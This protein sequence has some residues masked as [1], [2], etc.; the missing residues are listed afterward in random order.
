MYAQVHYHPYYFEVFLWGEI[1]DEAGKCTL[2]ENEE[3]VVFEMPKVTLGQ[4]WPSLDVKDL[5][6]NE[7]HEKRVRAVA[8]SQTR[9]AAKIETALGKNKK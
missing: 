5:P 3:A 8:L 7:K 9:S 4:E 6:R 1:D 2:N